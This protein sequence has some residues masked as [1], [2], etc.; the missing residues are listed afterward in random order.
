MYLCTMLVGKRY[1]VL[2]TVHGSGAIIMTR[3]LALL[4]RS[5]VCRRE[6]WAA[7]WSVH[8]R[9]HEPSTRAVDRGGDVSYYS[10]QL[11]SLTARAPGH[12]GRPSRGMAQSRNAHNQCIRVRDA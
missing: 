5:I 7:E 10:N 3:L 11:C 12:A 2:S 1:S 6:P 8:P 9:I 4:S